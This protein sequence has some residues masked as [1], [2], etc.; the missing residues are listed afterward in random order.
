MQKKVSMDQARWF[1]ELAKKYSYRAALE[2]VASMAT[3]RSANGNL[4]HDALHLI[5]KVESV[6]VNILKLKEK[7]T[8][9]KTKKGEQMRRGLNINTWPFW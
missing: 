6:A 8:K 2:L 9:K 1:F 4:I 3:T 5:E 7:K